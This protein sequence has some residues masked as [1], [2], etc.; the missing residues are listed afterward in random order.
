MGHD[1]LKRLA[2]RVPDLRMPGGPRGL[3]R[4]GAVWSRGRLSLREQGGSGVRGPQGGVAAP[5]RRRAGGSPVA[6]L[7]DRERVTRPRVGGEE[8]RRPPLPNKGCSLTSG[9]FLSGPRPPPL[10]VRVSLSGSRAQ[11]DHLRYAPNLRRDLPR[12]VETGVG[13]Q[14]FTPTITDGSSPKYS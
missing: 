13:S 3:E 2:V 14:H 9:P 4:K 1:V 5:D 7:G 11:S 8:R 6:P 12:T 10:R